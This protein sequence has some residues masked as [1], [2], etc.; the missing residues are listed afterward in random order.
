MLLTVLAGIPLTISVTAV[1]LVIGTIGSLPLLFGILS[2]NRL[3]WLIARG[4]IDLCR[5]I[6]I[7]VWMFILF[8]GV[9]IGGTKLSAFGAAV[10]GLGIV[11]AAYLAEIFRG[12]ISSVAAGQ[13][14]A[15]RALGMTPRAV[16]G[17]IVGPQA[18]RVAIPG[19]TTYGIGLLK[20]S[21]IASTIGVAE[22]VFRSNSY[23]RTTGEGITVFLVAAAIYVIVSVPVGVLS[24]KADEK[25]SAV[26][27]R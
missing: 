14:E 8:Y 23:A 21:S 6:P 27:A 19:Y 18:W 16:W 10:L 12:A 17:D 13:Y 22:M 5:G 4:I 26:V 15:A 7:V 3:V 20:D 11:S 2:G 25:L 9:T 24:R 1:A